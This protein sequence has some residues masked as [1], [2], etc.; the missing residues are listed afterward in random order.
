MAARAANL[1]QNYRLFDVPAAKREAP[2][3]EACEK[4]SHSTHHSSS[5]VFGV[6]QSATVAIDLWLRRSKPPDHAFTRTFGVS[7]GLALD[8]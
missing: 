6:H 8:E 1:L 2:Y 3:Y 7:R 5:G 4:A